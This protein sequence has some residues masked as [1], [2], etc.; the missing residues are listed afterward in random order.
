MPSFVGLLVFLYGVVTM[1][2]PDNRPAWVFSFCHICCVTVICSTS[3]DNVTPLS[4]MHLQYLELH[5]ISNKK[6]VS[7]IWS[8]FSVSYCENNPTISHSSY[9]KLTLI[10]NISHRR[11]AIIRCWFM[12]F[13]NYLFPD[14]TCVIALRKP[15]WCVPCAMSLLAAIQLTCMVAVCWGRYLH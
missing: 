8:Y 3:I 11:N 15:I 1:N 6:S 9:L 14:W 13:L 5:A 2:G 12:F 4:W 7:S 10:L